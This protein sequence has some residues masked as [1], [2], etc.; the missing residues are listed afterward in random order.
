MPSLAARGLLIRRSRFSDTSLITTWLTREHGKVKT[1][2]KGALRPKSSFLGKLDLF[3]HCELSWAQSR[4]ADLHVLREVKV[5][6]PFAHIRGTY[7]QTLAASYFAE[8]INE[9][10]EP[11]HP[12]P[13]LYE[14]LSRALNYLNQRLPDRRG[15][16]FFERELCKCLGVEAESDDAA[17]LRLHEVLGRLPKSRA[18]L[19]HR[20]SPKPDRS[21][22]GDGT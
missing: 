17:S 5:L 20:L 14:L 11:E 2:A 12:V 4:T 1:I 22:Q 6:E 13:E 3:F 19:L 8:L 16:L 18:E 7:L 10:T 15:V 9:A 21:A